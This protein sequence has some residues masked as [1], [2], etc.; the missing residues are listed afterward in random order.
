MINGPNN[1]AISR[2][3]AESKASQ[4]TPVAA[5][6]T[7]AA[8]AESATPTTAAASSGVSLSKEAQLLQRLEKEINSYPNM[9]SEK[10]ANIKNQLAA[11]GYHINSAS[12]AQ[13]MMLLDS[14]Y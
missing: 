11:G 5:P 14:L 8:P 7:N 13:K 3:T 2:Y 6:E 9:D 10:V 4:K 1:S 12:V